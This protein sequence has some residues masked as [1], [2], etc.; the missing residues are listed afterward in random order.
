MIRTDGVKVVF[1]RVV[2]KRSSVSVIDVSARDGSDKQGC[3]DDFVEEEVDNGDD[4]DN[5][6]HEDEDFAAILAAPATTAATTAPAT[7]PAT[8]AP[9]TT[10]PATAAPPVPGINIFEA[11][12]GMYPIRTIDFN[13]VPPPGW[14]IRGVDPGNGNTFT[15]DDGF[16]LSS[17][18]YNHLVGV[19]AYNR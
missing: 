7:T 2:P 4:G 3:A 9:A 16:S 11:R 13:M 18:E 19:P 14:A 17:R 10:A 6:D 5:D 8:T 12:P 1:V 15:I